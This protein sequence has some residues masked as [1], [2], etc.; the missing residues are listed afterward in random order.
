MKINTEES[1]RQWAEEIESRLGSCERAVRFNLPPVTV[2]PTNPQIGDAW[3]NTAQ[4]KAKMIDGTGTLR[5][6]NWT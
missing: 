6:L 3:L 2:D 4:N 5:I 1:L